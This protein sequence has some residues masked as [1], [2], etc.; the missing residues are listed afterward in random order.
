[1]AAAVKE[2]AK[3]L[4][5]S[6]N[7]LIIYGPL[8]ARGENGQ[9]VLNGLTN[10]ALATGHYDRLSYVGLDANSHGARDMGVLPNSLPGYAPLDDQAAV[11]RLGLLWNA[12]LSTTP[13]KSY[14][15]MLDEAGQ[16]IKALFI[17]GANPASE[18]PTWAENLDNLDLLVVQEL[19]LTETAAKAD[20]V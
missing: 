8:A 4:A 14:K 17:M 1:D 7:A 13:G 18:R 16:S 10:L 20:V 19:F 3:L 12:K 9:T 5:E 2:A 15:T 11:E 6:E